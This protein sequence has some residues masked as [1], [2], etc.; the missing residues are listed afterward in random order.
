MRQAQKY[1]AYTEHRHKLIFFVISTIGEIFIHL[2]GEIRSAPFPKQLITFCHFDERR[3]LYS[4]VW[5][6]PL[7]SIPET[8]N[9]FFVIS[10]IGEIFIHLFGEIRTAPFPK[11]LRFLTQF[12]MTKA[13]LIHLF[14]E[15]SGADFPKQ[16][17][18]FL[19]PFGMTKAYI[20]TK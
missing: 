5:G 11:Q 3:N 9:N 14:R 2:F 10:T 15:W 17:I 8:T 4:F 20:V 12:G 19:T 13:Y 1:I 16:L 18:R 6:N 7:R